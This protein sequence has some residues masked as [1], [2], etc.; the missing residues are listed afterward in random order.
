M[1]TPICRSPSLLGALGLCLTAGACNEEQPTPK[2]FDETGTWSVISYDLEGSGQLTDINNDR[3]RDAFMLSFD[4]VAKVVTSAACIEPDN[5]NIT[6]ANSPCTVSASTTE[7]EC[8]CFGYDFVREQM[9][10]REFNVGDLPP[11]VTIGGDNEPMEGGGADSGTGGGGSGGPAAS[12]EDVFINV[13]EIEDVASTFNFR[14][15]P[16]DL[17]GSNGESS[18]YIMQAR[19][20]SVFTLALEDTERPTCMPCVP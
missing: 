8:R 10:W 20:P 4:P 9:L 6:P 7:W 3:R 19:A 12:G 1:S 2:L 13:A 14:P 15:L 11:E 17:F 16:L 5:N 18:R